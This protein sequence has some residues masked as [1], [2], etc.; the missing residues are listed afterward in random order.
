MIVLWIV[1]GLFALVGVL[2]FALVLL[3]LGLRVADEIEFYT[4]SEE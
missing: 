4:N 3:E 2:V 1:L